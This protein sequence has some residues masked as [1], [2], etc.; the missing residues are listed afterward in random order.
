MKRIEVCSLKGLKESS[1]DEAILS[2]RRSTTR[3]L[4]YFPTYAVPKKRGQ[5]TALRTAEQR[6]GI[7]FLGLFPPSL[8][9]LSCRCRPF[10]VFVDRFL[11]KCVHC[12][13]ILKQREVCFLLTFSFF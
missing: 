8:A 10:A 9:C 11:T 4:F 1:V 5:E 12:F 2:S 7:D 6:R 13:D 3:E